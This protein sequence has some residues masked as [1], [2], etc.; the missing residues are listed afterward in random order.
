[1]LSYTCDTCID[2]FTDRILSIKLLCCTNKMNN[3]QSY[4]VYTSPC[5]ICIILSSLKKV[6]SKLKNI[7]L[8]LKGPPTHSSKLDENQDVSVP[9]GH[10]S[11]LHP[12]RQ[13]LNN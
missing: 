4:W 7:K 12:A 2:M 9:K 11:S 13:V 5:A 8:L 10:L 3:L 6:K 1:M